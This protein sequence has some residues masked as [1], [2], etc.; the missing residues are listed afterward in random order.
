MI[1]N[2]IYQPTVM[3]IEDTEDGKWL[4]TWPAF[5]QI[6]GE[7]DTFDEAMAFLSQ[8][9]REVD[10]GIE[11]AH[12]HGHPDWSHRLAAGPCTRND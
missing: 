6:V 2:G 1:R 4:V 10:A 9:K 7:E 12:R 11:Q 5:Q 8:F 3:G